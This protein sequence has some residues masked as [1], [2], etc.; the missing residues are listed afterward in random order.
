MRACVAFVRRG[1]AD[2]SGAVEARGGVWCVMSRHYG[3]N[4]LNRPHAPRSMFKRVRRP[5]AAFALG[6]RVGVRQKE[7]PYGRTPVHAEGYSA[8]ARQA[9]RQPNSARSVR[10]LGKRPR[11]RGVAGA[12]R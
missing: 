9:G 12:C 1:A 6:G 10:V 3:P 4:V 11:S 7:R 2:V 5:T 8:R